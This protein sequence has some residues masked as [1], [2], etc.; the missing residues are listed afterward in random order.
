MA[1]RVLEAV[2]IHEAVILWRGVDLSLSGDSFSD[3]VIDFSATV[4][5][6]ANKNL[7]ALRGVAD[8]DRRELFELRIGQQHDVNIL[9]MIKHPAVSSVNWGLDL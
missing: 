9:L 7:C 1:V 8:F 5:R 4:A 2:L 6:Q 3:H